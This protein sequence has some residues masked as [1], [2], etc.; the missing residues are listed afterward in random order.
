LSVAKIQDPQLLGLVAERALLEAQAA[1][2]R[3]GGDDPVLGAMQQ[4]EIEKLRRVL[5]LFVSKTSVYRRS[6]LD[7]QGPEHHLETLCEWEVKPKTLNQ[8]RQAGHSPLEVWS[9]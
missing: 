4:Q 9:Q 5:S 1:A 6:R 2:L 8:T 3:L 7:G